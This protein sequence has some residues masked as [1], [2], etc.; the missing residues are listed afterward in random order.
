MA[1]TWRMDDAGGEF[2]SE[3]W[4]KNM[5]S[6]VHP[7]PRG[8][9]D[10]KLQRCGPAIR[11]G[12]WILRSLSQP[13][14][15]HLDSAASMQH[16]STFQRGGLPGRLGNCYSSIASQATLSPCLVGYG[17]LHPISSTIECMPRKEIHRNTSIQASTDVN[18][19]GQHLV[20]SG[21]LPE[22]GLSVTCQHR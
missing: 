8:A 4:Q 9:Q 19:A 22:L 1:L 13:P 14:N 18:R 11:L 15:S 7:L 16:F 3:V 17:G 10:R 20:S 2:A 6:T 21:W 5:R 12:R